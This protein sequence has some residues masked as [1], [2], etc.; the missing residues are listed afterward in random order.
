M[1][2]FFFVQFLSELRSVLSRLIDDFH[3]TLVAVNDSMRRA[4]EVRLS[5][6]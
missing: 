3:A 1:L 2:C 4:K 6:Q 5:S